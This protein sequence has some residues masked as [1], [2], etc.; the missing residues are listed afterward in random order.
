MPG[1]ARTCKGTLL[2]QARDI[3]NHWR[4]VRRLS[5]LPVTPLGMLLESCLPGPT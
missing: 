3:E 5:P 2:R 4:V 1:A